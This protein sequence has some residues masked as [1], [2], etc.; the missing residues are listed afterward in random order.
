MIKQVE[1]SIFS[2]FKEWFDHT[3]LSEGQ[4]FFNITGGTLYSGTDPKLNLP[5]YAAPYYQW[6]FDQSISGAY[7]PTTGTG[8]FNTPYIDYNNGRTISGA[9]SGTINYSVKEF[10][11]YTST[12]SDQQII[13]EQK[14]FDRPK[15][16]TRTA[17]GL[18]PY[19]I[20]VPCIF[21]IP[22]KLKSNEIQVGGGIV[23]RSLTFSAIIV[24]DDDY[25]RYG[26]GSIFT[27][28]KNSY[29]PYFD[30]TPLNKLGGL[31]TG[32]YN[33]IHQVINYNIPS[34]FVYINNVTYT[35]IEHDLIVRNHPNLYFGKIYFDLCYYKTID[36]NL[37]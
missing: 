6:V 23:D 8:S 19:N 16:D 15:P 27:E 28:K 12:S 31:K 29:F 17:S 32:G 35:P 36:R 1:H 9:P 25:K 22:E 5:V 20:V 30:E 37:I 33:Y 13:F 2:S 4:A 18:A 14:Y 3:L 7:V 34:R 10:N 11:I 21:L 26:V 24:S